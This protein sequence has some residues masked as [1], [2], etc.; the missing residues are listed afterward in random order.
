[1]P[2][3]PPWYKEKFEYR[4]GCLV[5]CACSITAYK[6]QGRNEERVKLH[7]KDHAHVPGI[8]NVAI[9]RVPHPK[10]NRVEEGDFPNVMDIRQQRTSEFVLEAEIFEIAVKIKAGNT[11]RRYSIGKGTKYGEE[12]SLLECDIADW[13][14]E[15]YKKKIFTTSGIKKFIEGTLGKSVDTELLGRVIPKMEGYEGLLKMEA[16]YLKDREFRELI[17]YKKQ[18]RRRIK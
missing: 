14:R 7:I 8:Y 10:Y 5:E 12:W 13:V 15:A 1:M 4:I 11:L 2:F 17:A 6:E 18:K 9:S 3:C 16:P